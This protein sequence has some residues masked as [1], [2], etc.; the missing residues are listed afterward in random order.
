MRSRWRIACRDGVLLIFGI[1]IGISIAQVMTMV[2]CSSES[3]SLFQTKYSLP[4]RNVPAIDDTTNASLA[5]AHI[6]LGQHQIDP[7]QPR[8]KYIKD[9]LNLRQPLYAGVITAVNFLNTRAMDINGTWGHKLSN[10]EY[11]VAE[12][13][14]SHPL[15]IVSLKGVDDTYPPQKKVYRMLRYMH[16]KY[17]DKFNWFLRADDDSY[18]RVPELLEFLSKLDPTVPLYIGSPGLGRA[19]DLE[20]IKLFPH[21]RYCMGGPGVIFSR[22]LLIQLAPHL[23]D[24]L[25]NVVVSYNE[26]LEV[27]RC[28]S[29]KLG[30][31]CT[32]AYEVRKRTFL[33]VEFIIIL[34]HCLQCA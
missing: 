25:E 16:D 22:A 30:I 34:S 5:V 1:F 32:W 33:F 4:R 29:R 23:N 9:E 24:C 3:Q 2:H 6:R 10:V 17:I 21:E 7:N 19:E 15:S 31:Q 11:F 8:P 28:V 12:G 26:D 13:Q 20:R 18:I 27:G 14:G